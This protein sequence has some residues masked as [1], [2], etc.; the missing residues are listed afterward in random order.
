MLTAA[1]FFIIGIFV[2]LLFLNLYFRVKVLKFYKILVQN[3]VQF[4][5]SDI[6]SRQKVATIIDR[7]P[8][9]ATEIEGFIGHIRKSVIIAVILV[10]LITIMGVIL[11]AL[12]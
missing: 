9:F 8:S 7:N 1:K 10:A 11:H 12:K 3:R 2:S 5:A 4:D 6:F